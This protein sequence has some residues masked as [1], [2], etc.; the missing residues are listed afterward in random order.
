VDRVEWRETA[1]FFGQPPDARVFTVREDNAAKSHV[2][3][4][5]GVNGARLPR[6]AGNIV[7]RYRVGSGADAPAAGSLTVVVKPQPNLKAVRNPVPVGGGADP[8]PPNN[9]RQNAPRSVL[10][11]GR[12]VSAED[13]ATI[14]SQAPG[15]ARARAYWSWDPLQQRNTVKVF[16]G[17]DQAAVDAAT[18]ALKGADDPNRPLQVLPAKP[19]YSPDVGFQIALQPGY[20]AADMRAVVKNAFFDPQSGFFS[21]ANMQIGRSI[22]R[23]ELV[24]ACMAVPGVAAVHLVVFAGVPTIGGVRWDPGEGAYFSPRDWNFFLLVESA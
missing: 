6:G 20:L 15:V 5:D 12:A 10:A 13:Y 16:V 4:G 14:A 21:A 18:Q 7:A 24:A 9:I 23:S 3:F 19:I 8:D 22:F 1:S 2:R 17:D 11:F